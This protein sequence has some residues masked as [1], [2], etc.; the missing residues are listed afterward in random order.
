MSPTIKVGLVTGTVALGLVMG[1]GYL[2]WYEVQNLP[3]LTP[4][5]ISSLNKINGG[6]DSYCE[7]YNL[8][9]VVEITGTATII[10]AGCFVYINYS[11][12]RFGKDWRNFWKYAEKNQK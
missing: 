10:T 3:P 2:F 1:M 8:Q 5:E 4:D 6:C 11:D 9:T 12:W 7:S